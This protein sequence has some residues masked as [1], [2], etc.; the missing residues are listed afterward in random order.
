VRRG[1]Y[2]QDVG[3]LV[4]QSILACGGSVKSP[5]P[6]APCTGRPHLR[7]IRGGRQ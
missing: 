3:D 6:V 2:R 4:R 1:P 7:I 5:A